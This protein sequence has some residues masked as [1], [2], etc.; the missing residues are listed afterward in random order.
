[1]VVLAGLAALFLFGVGA[2]IAADARDVEDAVAG[3]L[4]FDSPVSRAIGAYVGPTTSVDTDDFE[5]IMIAARILELGCTT[6]AGWSLWA[7]RR[8][9]PVAASAAT[10]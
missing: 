1:V 2:A 7:G 3:G 6:A 8:R 9:V 5:Q 4:P 10:A